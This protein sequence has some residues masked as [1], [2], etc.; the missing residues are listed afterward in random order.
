MRD[1][2]R[3]RLPLSVRAFVSLTIS[4]HLLGQAQLRGNPPAALEHLPEK[5]LG[6]RSLGGLLGKQGVREIS[7]HMSP[8]EDFPPRWRKDVKHSKL[9]AFLSKSQSGGLKSP[10]DIIL[11]LSL[12]KEG[13]SDTCY[14]WVGFENIMLSEINQPQKASCC[15]VP[16]IVRL[17]ETEVG[18]QLL[19]LGHGARKLFNG[20]NFRFR[21]VL[22][23]T[24]EMV[25]NLLNTAKLS[26]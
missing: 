6:G 13:N 9:R 24:V 26:L 8:F 5:A 2:G 16:R 22:R 11:L 17:T 4:Q 15:E 21:R 14:T 10:L 1:K 3:D 19:G 25:E 18:W 23:W 20:D 12:K 7:R